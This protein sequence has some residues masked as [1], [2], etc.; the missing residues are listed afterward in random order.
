M[1]DVFARRG[2]VDCGEKGNQ[3][4]TMSNAENPGS[5]TASYAGSSMSEPSSATGRITLL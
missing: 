3:G 2:A 4:G 1:G 5:D